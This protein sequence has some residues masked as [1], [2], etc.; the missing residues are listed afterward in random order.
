MEIQTDRHTRRLPYASGLRPPRHNYLNDCR[1]LT[2]HARA[3][4]YSRYIHREYRAYVQTC[5]VDS[6]VCSITL[7]VSTVPLLRGRVNFDMI[8]GDL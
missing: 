2:A 6:C 5:D 8:V 3:V 1:Y 4:V 7:S